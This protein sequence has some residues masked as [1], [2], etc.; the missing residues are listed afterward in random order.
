[1]FVGFMRSADVRPTVLIGACGIGLGHVGRML[2]VARRLVSRGYKVVF[3][4]YG[5]AVGFCKREKFLTYREE[6]ISYGIRED[7]SVSLK[8]TFKNAPRLLKAFSD[9]V[10]AELAVIKKHRPRVVV[11]D[12]RLS[13]LLAARVLGVPSI[14]V[15][16]EFRL[17]LPLDVNRLPGLSLIKQL[18]ERIVLETFGIGWDL[19][20]V[21]LITDYPPPYTVSKYNVVIPEFLRHKAVFVGTAGN[22]R[23]ALSKSEARRLLGLEGSPVVYFGLSGLPVER[24]ALF[25]RF[26]P[27]AKG[28]STL[29]YTVLMSKGEPNGSTE[30]VRSGGV[31]VYEWLPDRSLGYAAADVFV[32]V[33]GQTSIGEVMKYGLPMVVVPTPNHTE[34]DAIA[35]SVSVMGLGYRIRVSELTFE[36]LA[37]SINSIMRDGYIE[38]A[39]QVAEALKN[40][41]AITTIVDTVEGFMVD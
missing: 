19:A 7:G 33:G 24:R 10:E 4:S 39:A 32:G 21:V 37:A 9:Q 1:M 14:L 3:T 31:T 15:M 30:P 35:E 11:S 38:R 16:H 8:L 28:L 2:P 5:D 26:L 25:E 29:G 22:T 34:H 41:D 13:T 18:V 36:R 20:N 6:S 27:L 12:S 40:Y 17:M 23:V